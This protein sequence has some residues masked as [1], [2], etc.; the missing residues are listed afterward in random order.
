MCFLIVEGSPVANFLR[1]NIYLTQK[2]DENMFWNIAVNDP[3][4]E[5]DPLTLLHTRTMFGRPDWN[6]IYRRIRDAIKIGRYLPGCSA[7]LR[8]K[9]GVRPSVCSMTCT[10]LGS[11]VLLWTWWSRHNHQGSYSEAYQSKCCV[12]FRQGASL[13]ASCDYFKNN[14][15]HLGA[16]LTC[17]LSHI[18][19]RFELA[20]L[21]Y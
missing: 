17:N 3:G 20:I 10:Y 13:C 11:D 19:S 15:Y 2:I 12:H 8:T 18:R 1:I 9:V 5:Y 21:L 14:P 6:S 4:A 16:F 7:Q